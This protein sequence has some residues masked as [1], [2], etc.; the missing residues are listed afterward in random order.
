MKFY[1]L[2][3]IIFSLLTFNAYADEGW[4]LVLV[5]TSGIQ[6]QLEPFEVTSNSAGGTITEKVGGIAKIVWAVKRA[7]EKFPDELLV[8]TS[9]DDVIGSNMLKVDR[10]NAGLL[11]EIGY[12][13]GTLGN[14]EFDLGDKILR[15]KLDIL[16]YPV[17]ASNIAVDKKSPLYGLIK[18]YHIINKNGLRIGF[19]GLLSPELPIVSKP[20]KYLKVSAELTSKTAHVVNIL[21]NKEKA[22]VVIGVVHI[23][24]KSAKK[25]AEKVAG[26]DV[27]CVGDSTTLIKSGEELVRTPKGS[28]IVVQ[29]G[30]R[31]EYLGILKLNVKNG[32]LSEH[33]WQ[34]IRMNADIKEDEKVVQAIEKYKSD[35]KS[36]EQL[37]V[38]NVNVDIRKPIIRTK[39]SSFASSILDG[40]RNKYKTDAAVLNSGAFRGDK[41]LDS[42]TISRSDLDMIFPY[43]DEFFIAE[44]QGSV[45]KQILERGVSVLPDAK[46]WFLQ[47]SGIKYE[48]NINN[49]PQELE[50]DASGTPV[51]VKHE[52]SRITSVRVMQDRK[53]L[54]LDNARTYKVLI[55]GFMAGGGDGF[56]MIPSLS[57]QPTGKLIK[58]AVYEY[59]KQTKRL[60]LKADGRIK[61]V[62]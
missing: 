19:F 61:I 34:P 6:G 57:L 51:G 26:I 40:M 11:S 32:K 30:S 36:S 53:Y 18:P 37:A 8:V 22:D 7:K 2:L 13:I 27:L 33:L 23:G 1:K 58:T 9:G 47:V 45:L 42:L 49:K 15:E 35:I 16:K 39:E 41:V 48:V 54:P 46:G 29:S 44:M 60:N 25:L 20:G 3:I 43:N 21:R 59:L 55:G 52:G 31:G 5:T 12:N 17:T 62:Y 28:T 10:G 38:T 24:Y 56:F 50:L 14:H 4:N